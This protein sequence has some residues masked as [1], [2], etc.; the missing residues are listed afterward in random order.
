MRSGINPRSE[1][2]AKT[3][4]PATD[5]RMQ[6]PQQKLRLF[7]IGLR[8]KCLI[9]GLLRSVFRKASSYLGAI[10]T[11]HRNGRGRRGHLGPQFGFLNSRSGG[12]NLRL[13]TS[14]DRLS[15]VPLAADFRPDIADQ[16]E[17]TEPT[18]KRCIRVI[19]EVVLAEERDVLLWLHP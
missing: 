16:L 15:V 18:R 8:C 5:F 13:R 7:L 19:V 12:L 9:F 2:V 10:G 4:A 6:S 17:G 1:A 3:I 14:G 11:Q